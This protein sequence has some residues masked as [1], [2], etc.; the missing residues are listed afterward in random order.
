MKKLAIVSIPLLA[1]AGA[2]LAT[3]V[4][5]TGANTAPQFFGADSVALDSTGVDTVQIGTFSSWNFGSAVTDLGSMGFSQFGFAE[6]GNV[7]GTLGILKGGASDNTAAADAFDTDKIYLVITD[8]DTGTFGIVSGTKASNWTFPTNLGGSGDTLN[9]LIEDE[10]NQT[11]NL[12]AVAGG[13]QVVPEP[14]TYA[15]LAG[16][17]A[18][19]WVMLRRRRG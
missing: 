3:T 4:N 7:F 2:A 18:L 14:S 17:C 6:V 15:A 11:A 9:V 5:L 10:V 13:F 1:F 8:G 19:G 12:S 16:F